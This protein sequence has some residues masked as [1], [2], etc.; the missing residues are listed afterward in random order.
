MKLL[1]VVKKKGPKTDFSEDQIFLNIRQKS[2]TWTQENQLFSDAGKALLEMVLGN[3]GPLQALEFERTFVY[4]PHPPQP[5][6]P[7]PLQLLPQLPPRDSPP[8]KPP[9]PTPA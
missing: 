1:T 3:Q 7:H 6:P 5:P 4:P 2:S 9:S 8:I